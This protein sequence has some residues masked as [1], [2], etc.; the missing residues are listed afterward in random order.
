MRPHWLVST[1]S[2]ALATLCASVVGIAST[3]VGPLDSTRPALASITA[4]VP[5]SSTNE[6]GVI[7]GGVSELAAVDGA[8]MQLGPGVTRSYRTYQLPGGVDP[9]DIWSF[10]VKAQYFGPTK[11]Q[12]LWRWFIRDVTTNKWVLLGDNIESVT[13]NTALQLRFY[14]PGPFAK[15]VSP[16]GAIQVRSVSTNKPQVLQLDAEWIEFDAS[17]VVPFAGWVPSVGTRW[18]YQLQPPVDTTI[19]AVPWTGGPAVRPDVFDIDLYEADGVTPASA[20]VAAIH[21]IDARAICYVS[22]GTYENWR[23]DAAAFPAVVL[24]A[25]NG[26][27]G[28]KWL[29]IRRLD[30]ILPIMSVRVQLCAAA[31]FDAVEF[32]NMDAAFN[33]SGF[34]V[35]KAQQIEFNRAMA[36]VA[37]FHGLAVG[38]KNDVAQLTQLEPWYEFAIN[39]QCSQ[40]TECSGYDAWTQAGKAVA[41]VEYTVS[42]ATFCPS[43]IAGGRSGIKKDLLLLATPYTPCN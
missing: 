38:L 35:S 41:Q 7:S 18:Q 3:A 30:V 12:Q 17:A 27:P 2:V 19:T 43:A 21:A 33:R 13:A 1:A 5:T 42:L 10:T 28:E 8:A 29:D 24:G 22:A 34:K 16:G 23:P 26:W 31:G 39:E 11:A 9:A 20:A 32:D 6:F 36:G 4:L 37:H 40:Y 15:Y 14:P 25:S